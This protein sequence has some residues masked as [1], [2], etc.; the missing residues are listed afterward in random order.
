[1]GDK[2]DSKRPGPG[3]LFW[4]AAG[5]AGFIVIM[6]ANAL[7]GSVP[8]PLV[9]LVFGVPFGILVG[10]A[11]YSA[12]QRHRGWIVLAVMVTAVIAAW[13]IILAMDIYESHK[14]PTPLF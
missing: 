13:T 1:M 9:G 10:T 11:A 2:L 7:A 4:I 14:G 12:L 8:L 6:V 5:G 3:G